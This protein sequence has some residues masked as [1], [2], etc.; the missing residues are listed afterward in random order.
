MKINL[1]IIVALFFVQKAVAD[2][3]DLVVAKDGSGQ[4]GTV[5]QAVDAVPSFRKHVTTI[6]VKCGVYKE[7]IIIPEQKKNIRIVG[8]DKNHTIITYDD[9]AQRKNRFNEEIGT[10][11]SASFYCSG[12]GF[13]AENITF[14]NSAGPVG[15]AVAMWV[16]ADKATFINCRFLG[17]QDTLYT[18]GKEARQFYLNCY[19][20]GTVD[21]IFGSSTAWFE[22]CQ[23]HCKRS[24]YITAASTPEASAFGYVFNNCTVTGDDSTGPFYLGRP[25]RPFAKVLFMNSELPAFIVAEGW[26]NWGKEENEHTALFAEY[27][28][29]GPGAL[30]QNRV[31]WSKKLSD[32]EAKSVSISAVF[33]GWEPA[34]YKDRKADFR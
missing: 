28:N 7:K 26:H 32:E 18:Y 29:T 23:L 14:E 24:G 30:S 19:I 4:F 8:E 6:F 12:E 9:Y 16:S 33:G 11:G 15:Q 13:I 25:W 2:G 27:N 20:E 21:Y 34:G 17:F 22:R 10:S 31:K 3:Y 5:Q 1:L